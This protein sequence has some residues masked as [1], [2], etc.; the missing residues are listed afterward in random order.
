MLTLFDQLTCLIILSL[1][2]IKWF[3]HSKSWFLNFPIKSC[4]ANNITKLGSFLLITF[5]VVNLFNF[6][7]NNRLVVEYKYLFETCYVLFW[8]FVYQNITSENTSW[9][10]GDRLVLVRNE[11]VFV[12]SIRSALMNIMSSARVTSEMAHTCW[13]C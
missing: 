13:K 5:D 1:L 8:N 4:K 11:H 6:T 2:Q 3:L 9:Q 10:L 12:L 7:C